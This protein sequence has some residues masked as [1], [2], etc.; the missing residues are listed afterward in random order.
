MEHQIHTGEKFYAF[1]NARLYDENNQQIASIEEPMFISVNLSEI[2]E[3]D[4]AKKEKEY[5]EKYGFSGFIETKQDGVPY[6][7]FQMFDDEYTAN[8]FLKSYLGEDF[9]EF[10]GIFEKI[11]DNY[12][13]EIETKD[14][15]VRKTGKYVDNYY[16]KRTASHFTIN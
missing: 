11:T 15:I 14:G 1:H 9:T 4:F 10:M 12:E 6:A 3:E 13:A 7:V 8:K 5:K 2:S 16:L